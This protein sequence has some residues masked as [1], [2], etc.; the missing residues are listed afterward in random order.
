MQCNLRG[1]LQRAGQMPDTPRRR[2]HEKTFHTLSSLRLHTLFLDVR[3]LIR[4]L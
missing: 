4:Y 1:T 2:L 3:I